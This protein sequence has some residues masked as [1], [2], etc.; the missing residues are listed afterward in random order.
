MCYNFY[1]VFSFAL[2]NLI[3]YC[4]QQLGMALGVGAETLTLVAYIM[5]MRDRVVS[6][7]EQRF[8]GAI[9]R[10]LM[11]GVF[12]VFA[13][14]A[15]ITGVMYLQQDSIAASNIYL[16]KCALIGLMVLL[17][18]MARSP[19][20]TMAS[21][22]E[23][24][25]GG[26]WFALFAVHILQPALPLQQLGIFYGFWMLGFMLIWTVLV[27][28]MRDKKVEVA[29]GAEAY[30]VGKIP[31]PSVNLQ[32]QTMRKPYVQPNFMGQEL[33]PTMKPAPTLTPRQQIIE[34]TAMPI[35][36]PKPTISTESAVF[37][38]MKASPSMPPTP[39]PPPVPRP[40][41]MRPLAPAAPAE[42]PLPP[43]VLNMQPVGMFPSPPAP[44]AHM[45]A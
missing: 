17:S 14:A 26:T 32:E 13:S 44:P 12:L 27:F 21:V 28:T 33:A 24:L 19:G 1:M 15:G 2:L 25:V 37:A 31:P 11:V 22:F 40:A 23:G 18:L 6:P 34:P 42:P 41:P 45:A 4:A 35:L 9:R 8:N 7:D 30:L 16:F 43:V 38:P 20:S 10:V 36:Q 39:I 29:S 3:C 5:T